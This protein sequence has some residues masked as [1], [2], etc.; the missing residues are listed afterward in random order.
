MRARDKGMN[1]EKDA[2]G[3]QD[4]WENEAQVKDKTKCYKA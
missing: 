4:E 3:G 2:W 1:K